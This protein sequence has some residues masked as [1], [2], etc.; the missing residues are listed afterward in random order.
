MKAYERKKGSKE[1][2]IMVTQAVF[3]FLEV[4]GSSLS[5]K[6][7]VSSVRFAWWSQRTADHTIVHL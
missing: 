6:T 2:Y 5:G 3:Q 7:P 1:G 4:G